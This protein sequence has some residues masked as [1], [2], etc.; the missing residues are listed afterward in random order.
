MSK[1]IL[2]I[3]GAGFVGS[4]LARHFNELG[5]KVFVVDNLVRRGSENNLPEFKRLGISFQHGDIRNPEDVKHL[6]RVDAVLLT[7]AQPCAINYSNP[8]FDFTNNTSGVLNV[9]NWVGQTKT[10]LI[11]WSTNKTYTG[12]H[13]NC[14]PKE[15]KGKRLVWSDPD[16]K[17]EGWSFEKGFNENLPVDGKDH[18]IY[19]YSKIAADLMIQEWADAYQIPSIINRFSCLAGP[20]Q[21]GKAEQGWVS[22]FVL[23]ERLKLPITIYGYGG[24]QVR[25]YLFTPD[26]NNLISK[27]VDELLNNPLGN[28]GDVYNVGGGMK[29][30]ISINEAI[31]SLGIKSFT[32]DG[33]QRR[34]D[35]GI[36]ISD[37][38]KAQQK[39]GWSPSID[40]ETGTADIR[41][42]FYDNEQ[43]IKSIYE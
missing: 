8:E 9:L 35:Q 32:I 25:D 5:D 37:N 33:K 4:N 19:G 20:N 23:A 34:A 38:T 26:I 27:Q 24:N 2:I 6:P 15:L 18:S 42:W 36:Y 1:R 16:Y 30:N 3:G 21:W 41:Q 11:F 10:P 40:F 31:E 29:Y 14:I 12:E 43:M 28:L 17:K 13:T 22:W 39:F 7:A